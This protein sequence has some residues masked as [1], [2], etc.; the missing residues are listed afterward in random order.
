MV[1]WSMNWNSRYIFTI[2]IQNKNDCSETALL[3]SKAHCFYTW[4]LLQN[5]E[6]KMAEIISLEAHGRIRNSWHLICQNRSSRWAFTKEQR[7]R[8]ELLWT[9]IILYS[10]AGNICIRAEHWHNSKLSR[11]DLDNKSLISLWTV[12]FLY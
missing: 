5:N 1:L 6:H 8:A 10:Y 12:F 4:F 9:A 11:W 7:K 2:T 3:I